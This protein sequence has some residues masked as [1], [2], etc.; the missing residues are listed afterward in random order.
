MNE[1][2]GLGRLGCYVLHCLA[3]NMKAVRQDTASCPEHLHRQLHRCEKHRFWM[4]E[5]CHVTWQV[6]VRVPRGSRSGTDEESL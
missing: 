1:V 3:P 6:A 4:H 5:F 2:E